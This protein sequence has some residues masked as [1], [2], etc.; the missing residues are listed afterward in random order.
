MMHTKGRRLRWWLILLSLACVVAG[1]VVVLSLMGRH[2]ADDPEYV[3][4]PS[5]A[6]TSATVI[7][8]SGPGQP[9]LALV[10]ATTGLAR[11][12]AT[13]AACQTLLSS[14]LPALGEPPAI[15]ALAAGIPDAGTADLVMN[16]L[17]A[18][19][20]ALSGCAQGTPGGNDALTF[21]RAVLSRRL[22]DLGL[23]S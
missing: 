16:D 7:Y 3:A 6:D 5:I 23:Q 8:L 17:D 15:L 18:T 12:D 1:V 13:Q 9:L 21:S 4:L 14:T 10:A 11:G 20:S 19:M 2:R 22:A